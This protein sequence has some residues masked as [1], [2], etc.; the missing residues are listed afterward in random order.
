MPDKEFQYKLT[1]ASEANTSGIDKMAKAQGELNESAEQGA[2]AGQK[3]AGGTREWVE[4]T[5]EGTAA[6]KKEL[7]PLKKSATTREQAARAVKK[8][9]KVVDD[10]TVAT[11]KSTSALKQNIS[12]MLAVAKSTAVAAAAWQVGK[13]ALGDLS[14]W[15]GITSVK[16]TEQA[17][18]EEEAAIASMRSTREKEVA[19]NEAAEAVKSE[20]D[21][22]ARLTG[23]LDAELKSIDASTAA[24]QRNLN[25]RNAIIDAELARD[26]AKVNAG[27]GSEVHK[28]EKVAALRAEHAKKQQKI[29]EESIQARIKAE[30]DKE[31]AAR[32]RLGGIGD[33]A[34]DRVLS[35][36]QQAAELLAESQRKE[37]L[38]KRFD[39]GAEGA[40]GNAGNA[41]S[42]RFKTGVKSRSD[43]S[44]V[45]DYAGHLKNFLDE[46]LVGDGLL[47]LPEE[48][49]SQASNALGRF[50][51]I[52][53]K[54]SS[55]TKES[56]SEKL[57][58]KTLT[59]QAAASKADLDA[60]KK[61]LSETVTSADETI[62]RL[63]QE[64]ALKKRLAAIN[65]ET[66][67]FQ[68]G[69]RIK[70]ARDKQKPVTAKSSSPAIAAAINKGDLT[71]GE[72]AKVGPALQR[73]FTTNAD[74]FKLMMHIISTSQVTEKDIMRRLKQLETRNKTTR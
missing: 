56:E 40:A 52:R 1:L 27:G 32:N 35:K 49:H 19:R 43:F 22:V 45:D 51:S 31:S 20:A 5:E 53:G 70:G 34:R 64:L 33:A 44:N 30:Q 73:L 17:L 21:E 38:V 12:R 41:I 36:E 23:I 37:E 59:D 26:I 16:I 48:L 55:L 39:V 74:A 61:R 72:A 14:R 8:H 54:Q 18:A 7:P 50:D 62:A 71:V 69:T 47:Q 57:Q 68:S 4:A 29:D 9:L 46:T 65:R 67:G 58:A 28:L 42:R 63:E 3:L 66:E 15:L 10:S 25:A 6:I 24:H 13:A 60:E 2:F 11:K